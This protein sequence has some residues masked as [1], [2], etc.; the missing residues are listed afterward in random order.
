MVDEDFPGE[1][2][3]VPK[4]KKSTGVF[5]RPVSNPGWLELGAF[6]EL[7]SGR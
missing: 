6:K 5:Q 2:T 4:N 3:S 1:R 7:S